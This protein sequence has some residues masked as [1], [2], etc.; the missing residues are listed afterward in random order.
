MKTIENHK[1]L[2]QHQVSS[3]PERTAD[4]GAR[5]PGLRSG[6]GVRGAGVGREGGAQMRIPQ[7]RPIR[8]MFTF[9]KRLNFVLGRGH[10]FYRNLFV[11]FSR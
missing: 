7:P 9:R 1:A 8:E 4:T 3:S 2:Q 5:L 10:H 6:V 11:Y